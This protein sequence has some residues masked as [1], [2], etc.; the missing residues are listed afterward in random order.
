MRSLAPCL[1]LALLLASCAS[2]P[3]SRFYTLDPVPPRVQLPAAGLMLQVAA[4]HIP[5]VLQRQEMVRESAPETLHLSDRNRWGAPL[6]GMIQRVLEQD[7]AARLPA[8]TVLPPG[9]LPPAG[10]HVL[11][12]DVL[13]F[14]AGPSGT[15]RLEGSW[16]QFAPGSGEPLLPQRVQLVTRAH[17]AGGSR[18]QAA[19]MSRLLGRLADRIAAILAP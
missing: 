10:T 19:A 15:V 4:V 9:S 17:P 8:S 14:D 2:S 7:L 11:V 3:P 18:G 16:A 1:V 6:A 13:R 5:E 12:V